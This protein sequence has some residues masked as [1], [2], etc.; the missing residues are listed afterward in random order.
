L[1]AALLPDYR[2]QREIGAGASSIIYDLSTAADR[3]NQVYLVRRARRGE[4]W[5]PPRRLINDG[6]NDPKWL[7][8]GRLIAH[9][10][11]GELRVIAPDGPGGDLWTMELIA[12]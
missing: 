8:D 11:N 12:K 5:G 10:V 2:V 4:P 3:R 1:A 6:S 7:P 9:C